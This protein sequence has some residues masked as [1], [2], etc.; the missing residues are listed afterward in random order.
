M[1][2]VLNNKVKR[3]YMTKSKLSSFLGQKE[4]KYFN[5]ESEETRTWFW[6]PIVTLK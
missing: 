1:Y 3:K 5:I 4:L 2:G 6:Y